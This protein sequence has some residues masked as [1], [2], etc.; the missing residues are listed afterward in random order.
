MFLVFAGPIIAAVVC[1]VAIAMM[2]RM[3]QESDKVTAEKL[4]RAVATPP[5]S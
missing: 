1:G 3:L 2:F 4:A 5:A